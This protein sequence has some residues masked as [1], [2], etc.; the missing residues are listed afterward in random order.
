MFAV[1]DDL[2]IYVTRG[3]IVSFPVQD[4]RNGKPRKFKVGEVVRFKVFEKKNCEKVVLQKD[5]PVEEEAEQVLIVLTAR[6]TK[7]GEVIS[8]PKDYWYEVELNPY[9]NNETFIGYDEG[10]A[11]LFRLYPEGGDAP[12]YEPEPE[13]FPVV[14]EKLDMTSPRPVANQ[15]IARAFG[16]LKADFGATKADITARAN[17]AIDMVSAVGQSVEAEKARLDNIVSGETTKGDEVTD[18]RVDISGKT[19]GSAGTAV[20]VQVANALRTA[21]AFGTVERDTS[22]WTQ[23]NVIEGI[24]WGDDGTFWTANGTIATTEY[25]TGYTAATQMFPILPNCSYK[26]DSFA[27][28]IFLFDESK[29][30][31]EQLVSTD[32][33]KTLV[34]STKEDQYYIAISYRNDYAGFGAIDALYR[35]S[36]TDE[37]IALYPYVATKLHIPDSQKQIIHPMYGKTI[38]NFGDSVFGNYFPPNDISSL[39]AEYTGAKVYNCGFGGCRMGRHIDERWDAFSM[40]RLADAIKNND[41]SLQ[42]AVMADATWE[43]PSYFHESLERLKSIDFNSVDIVTIAYGTNDF[44]G[45][46]IDIASDPLSIYTFAGAL[47]YSIEALLTA[48]PNLHIM[49]CSP[50]YRFWMDAE[51]NVVGDSDNYV[52]NN[53]LLVDFVHAAE[54]VAAEYHVQFVNNYNNLGIGRANRHYYFSKTDSVHPN[55]NGRRLIARHIAHEMY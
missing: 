37:E 48:Y 6:D 40:Y 54:T 17:E 28:S 44:G 45:L 52:S 11:R 25:T 18:I 3:D 15:V 24:E 8:K 14:D 31:G 35:T 51:G 5:F 2:S 22:S 33:N 34:F 55:E 23:P 47:R 46:A 21:E 39:L 49:V 32:P 7:I 10:G 19:H 13:S 30:N 41:F 43:E 1:N 27:G 4:V 12:P 38:V 29:T 16:S 36:M 42:D 9:D 26:V 50:V 20:R 53:S